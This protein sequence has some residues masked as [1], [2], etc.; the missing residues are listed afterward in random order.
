MPSDKDLENRTRPT[1]VVGSPLDNL[2]RH[3][4]AM[5][6]EDH[7]RRRFLRAA[8]MVDWQQVLL[9]GGPPCFYLLNDGDPR[10]CLAAERWMGHP[11]HHPFVSLALLLE[12]LAMPADRLR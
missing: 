7:A 12:I 2:V 9:N 11:A 6:L 5:A 1:L 10:F 8:E 4:R 3:H